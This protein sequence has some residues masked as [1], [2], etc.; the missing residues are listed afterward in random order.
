MGRRESVAA[1]VMNQACQQ[2]RY[3]RSWVVSVGVLV[4]SKL[5]LNLLPKFGRDD[6]SMF[7]WIDLPFVLNFPYVDPVLQ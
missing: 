1:I 3:N 4:S 7:T 2:V 6:P 5:C